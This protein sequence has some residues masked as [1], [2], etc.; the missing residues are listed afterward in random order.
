VFPS[1]IYWIKKNDII[2]K[3]GYEWFIVVSSTIILIVVLLCLSGR[4]TLSIYFYMVVSVGLTFSIS[5]SNNEFFTKLFLA[6]MSY[7]L[8]R[9]F[10]NEVFTILFRDFSSSTLEIK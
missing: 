9:M 5:Y 6:I 7:Y 10:D 4:P 1:A 2:E 3:I 8:G